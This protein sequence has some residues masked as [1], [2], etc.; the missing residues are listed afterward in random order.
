MISPYQEKSSRKQD[1]N[2]PVDLVTTQITETPVIERVQVRPGVFE[3]GSSPIKPGDSPHTKSSK[4]N[5]QWTG[6]VQQTFSP[7]TK[8]SVPALPTHSNKSTKRK[9]NFS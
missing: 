9:L 8:L 4:E 6:K 2:S 3:I 1:N 5:E 7:P